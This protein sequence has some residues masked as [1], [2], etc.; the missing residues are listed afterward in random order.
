VNTPTGDPARAAAERVFDTWD[1]DPSV[2]A[3]LVTD[4]DRNKLMALIADALTAYAAEQVRAEREATARALRTRPDYGFRCQDCGA[5]HNLD[6]SIPSE[7]WNAICTNRP[8]V[9]PGA[10]GVGMPE[11]GALCTLC[12]DDRLVKAGLTCNE[13]EFYFVG[14]ALRGKLYAESHGDVER[15]ERELAE[16]LSCLHQPN[17]T[18]PSRWDVAP[19]QHRRFSKIVAALRGRGGEMT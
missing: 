16:V 18:D 19:G 17:P 9:V 13:A 6:T 15:L 1:D 14:Q 5:P 8:G 3:Y 12:I 10:A 7:T 2:V 11:A 4:R